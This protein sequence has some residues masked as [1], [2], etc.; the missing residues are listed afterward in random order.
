MLAREPALGRVE[1]IASLTTTTVVV[2]ALATGTV[3]AGKF[4]EKWLLRNATAAPADRV[5]VSSGFASATGTFSHAGANYTDTTATAEQVEILE[6][7]PYLFDQA[8]QQALSKTHRV[9]SY[10]LPT[11]P[12]LDRYSLHGL[13]WINEPAD[14][15]RV[16]RKPIG[17]LTR[18]RR[19]DRWEAYS[20]GV[21]TAEDWTTAG[22]GATF[23]R[24]A[25]NV[26]GNQKYVMAVT[27]A[28]A[29]AT[30]TQTYE[31]LPT[32]DVD[33]LRGQLVTGVLFGRSG[34]AASLTVT[35][36]SLDWA[37]NVLSST[38]SAAHDGDS[39][40]QELTAEH[41]VHAD[42]ERVAIVATTAVNGTEQIAD[43]YLCAGALTD[44]VRVDRS[45]HQ[46]ETLEPRF[47]VAGGQ[48]LILPVHGL[49]SQYVIESYR[50]Y[51]QFT[52][53]RITAGTADGDTTDAPLALCAET[54]L[55]ELYRAL[56]RTKE[57]QERAQAH[58]RAMKQ[59]QG[60]H[61]Y[62]DEDRRLG[63]P[64]PQPLA[65]YGPRRVG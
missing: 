26:P 41:T 20:S 5:R 13:S 43:M 58:Y 60:R 12:G 9:V 22:S 36:Q 52:A 64:I 37:G 31:V 63:L 16:Y 50:A 23:A 42:A 35:V 49:G 21:L 57:T 40:Y 44:D 34:Q 56:P 8:I 28:G 18:N 46:W 53:S 59:M 62:R 15:A 2:P 47:D 54:A 14:V 1:D 29:D 3:T 51:P 11:R 48:Y 32:G 7:E 4:T 10:E 45:R 55:Y 65:G 33:D 39:D 27:R 6:H 17:V 30:V 61:L 19:F 38:S 25:A 24:S